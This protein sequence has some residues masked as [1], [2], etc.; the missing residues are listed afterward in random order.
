MATWNPGDTVYHPT[1]PTSDPALVGPRPSSSRS[2]QTTAS[3][4]PYGNL[5]GK[6]RDAAVA[7]TNLFASY[8][9][10]S[11]AP[12]IIEFI[13][14]G[15]SADTI[16]IMLQTTKEYKTRFAANEDRKA[17]GLPV[18]SPAEYIATESAY[19]QTL[20]K[21][22]MPKGFYDSTDDFRS[23]LA[24]DMSPVELDQRAQAA[25]DFMNQADSHEMAFYRQYYT[26]GDLVAFALDPKRAA[27]LV[28]KAFQASRIGGT[29]QN[30]GI[31]IDKTQAERLANIGVTDDQARAGFG[32][33]AQVQGT[34]N[35]LGQ[36]YGG[37]LSQNDLIGATF[38]DDAAA[39]TKLKKLASKE[40]AAFGGSS[41]IGTN[42]LASNGAVE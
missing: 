6:D 37:G 32:Q 1:V 39:T 2:S 4:D 42:S 27:P 29:A 35:Q 8:G 7:L 38:A 26:S 33:I 20:S 23:F 9:L 30:Q 31:G 3:N 14:N 15:Y 13:K 34:V 41:A 16:S 12:K 19:R 18:L 11:L 22:G 5:T 40:R 24:N 10:A 17:K 28:G 25:S 36:I 21:W